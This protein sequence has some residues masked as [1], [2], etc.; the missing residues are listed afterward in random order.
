MREVLARGVKGR[1][2][3]RGL[4]TVGTRGAERPRLSHRTGFGVLQGRGDGAVWSGPFP[5]GQQ[6]RPWVRVSSDRLLGGGE[7]AGLVR[8]A[9][10]LPS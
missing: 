8:T 5:M 6:A 10:P 4:L 9:R 2:E 1:G 7:G 3:A